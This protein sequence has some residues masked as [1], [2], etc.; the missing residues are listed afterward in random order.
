ME[1][2]SIA[3]CCSSEDDSSFVYWEL[4]CSAIDRELDSSSAEQSRILKTRVA[5]L[6][7]SIRILYLSSKDITGSSLASEVVAGFLELSTKLFGLRSIAG[8]GTGLGSTSEDA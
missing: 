6:S 3:C 8:V 1:D 7:S 4:G 5:S 2:S